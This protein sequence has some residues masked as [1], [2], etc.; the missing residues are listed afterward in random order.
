MVLFG[1][2]E[3]DL[4][5]LWSVKKGRA[6]SYLVGTVH[7]FPFSFRKAI[8]RLI[9]DVGAVFVEGPLDPRSMESVLARGRQGEEGV[10]LE[11]LDHSTIR[12]I[13]RVLG[14]S[15]CD[16]CSI[17]PY[18][19]LFQRKGSDPFSA[20]IQGLRPWMGF[21]QTWVQ[22]LKKRG[23][24]YSMDM[25][26]YEIGKALG[27]RVSF[28]ETIEEQI[29]ALDRIPLE[30]IVAFFKAVEQWER[31]IKQH[32]KYYLKGDLE[33]WPSATVAF[34]TRCDVIVDKRDPVLFK[35]MKGAMAEGGV[36][37][38]IGI[39]HVVTVKRLL[40]EEGFEVQQAGT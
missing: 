9:R 37:V 3:R 12:K 19:D 5:M 20:Q 32:V 24:K 40:E 15:A 38:F 7:F 2:R 25:D 10:L 27:K 34:P 28:L 14:Y 6:S 33:A 21:F 23:W 39:P 36:A 13:N 4:S 1:S 18:M 16:A 31:F 22:F 29:A 11:A 35:R 30:R 26:A 8:T 17:S